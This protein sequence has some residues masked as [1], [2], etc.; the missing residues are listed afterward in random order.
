MTR[1]KNLVDQALDMSRRARMERA[2]EMGFDTERVL[3][4]GTNQDFAEFQ[5]SEDGSFG[6]WLT[7][8]PEYA[9]RYTA[10]GRYRDG[11]RARRGRAIYP[12][13]TA[14][15]NPLDLRAAGIDVQEGNITL[16]E[17]AERAGFRFDEDD[18]RRAAQR[19]VDADPDA[20]GDSLDPLYDAESYYSQ[21]RTV[22]SWMDDP[23]VRE[24]LLEQGFDGVAT[25]EA[26]TNTMMA[27]R[28]QD[29]RS[30]NAA[31]DPAQRDSS[32][33]LAGVGTAAVGT[34]LLG[35]SVAPQEAEA[36]A[37]SKV[38]Q[39]LLDMSRRAR[40]ERAREMG[41]DTDRVLFHG[42]RADIDAFDADMSGLGTH[43]GSLEQAQ[44]RLEHTADV[45]RTGFRGGN[46]GQDANVMP[47]RARFQ[48]PLDMED[49]GT[50][51]DSATVA[52]RLRGKGIDV[53]DELIDE[54]QEIRQSFED[55]QDWI[56]S[57]ENA[58]F[59]GELR[60]AI[61][62]AGYDSIRYAN[63]VENTFGDVAD[64]TPAARAR[65]NAI[66]REINAID[67]AERARAPAMPDVSSLPEDEIDAALT[68]WLEA[69][70]VKRYTPDEAARRE[71]LLAESMEIERTGRGDPYSYIA[72]DDSQL[73]S[74]N[75]AFDPAQR[76]SSNLL[77][78]VGGAAVGAGI[79]GAGVAPQEAEAA[80]FGTLARQL[81]MRTREA[82]HGSKRR[83]DQVDLSNPAARG[84]G[85]RFQGEGFYAAADRAEAEGFA[86]FLEPE[87][88]AMSPIWPELD[89]DELQSVL[90]YWDR[91]ADLD[92]LSLDE[93]RE[94]AADFDEDGSL[95]RFA[96]SRALYRVEVP[97]EGLLDFEAAISDQPE[98]IQR[99]MIGAGASPEQS[100]SL[101]YQYLQ[102]RVGSREA[103]SALADAGALGIRYRDREM[104][105]GDLDENY[106]I[107]DDRNVNVVERN[108]EPV[109]AMPRGRDEPMSAAAG[110]A[111]PG[112]MAATGAA[113]ALASFLD[114]RSGKQD[115]PYKRFIAQGQR[116][117]EQAIGAG[118]NIGNLAASI[119][120]EPIAGYA[121]LVA[122]PEAV[123]RARDYFAPQSMSPAAQQQMIGLGN[124]LESAGQQ[125]MSGLDV[126]GQA[127][128]VDRLSDYA[129]YAPGYWEQ[130]VVP[131]LQ[132]Q[133]GTRAGSALAAT[134]RAAPEAL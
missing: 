28:P 30:V 90:Q 93:L 67:E 5:R 32:N 53:P 31:F 37:G 40:M 72:L 80:P 48:R 112:A 61:Q 82:W 125:I 122:G 15:N 131:A 35:A 66:G 73:R 105:A 54:A 26:G 116:A 24:T 46:Y 107:F 8:S 130:R 85:K 78:G 22:W 38:A 103:S 109:A 23:F 70:Q 117:V 110:F 36:G 64:L 95:S 92:E 100:V 83:Y 76:D 1:I 13:R 25:T 60:Q 10:G 97:A 121:G 71:A 44:R 11:R 9:N 51:N 113:G 62:D 89:R 84:T 59:M 19:L 3:F 49:V 91:N 133:F 58:E 47:L 74:V 120:A 39:G 128:G 50:W 98:A 118:E 88:A 4:H 129:R 79:L 69:G 63:E 56:E 21:P 2:R 94:I 99:L 42:T 96:P 86:D 134:L 114:M 12:V 111:R 14:I 33:L 68:Q 65:K 87:A 41:F 20:F 81:G 34:G 29:I 101:G 123:Q 108:G 43:V 126:A 55:P 102:A 18:A 104:S 6:A 45:Y 127:V 106:V 119:L 75:A 57:A 124:T 7:D 132:R 77:A 17:L 27:L 16:P 52:F 115:T